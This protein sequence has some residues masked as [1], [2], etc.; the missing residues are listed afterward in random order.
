MAINWIEQIKNNY[1][2]YL[3]LHKR[4]VNISGI[5]IVKID[6]LSIKNIEK[7]IE[8]ISPDIIINCIGLTNIEECEK[9]PEIAKE[10]NAIIP[11]NV[12]KICKKFGIKFIQISTDHLFD[13]SQKLYKEEDIPNPQNQYAISK[14]QAEI[15]V[16]KILNNVSISKL[17]G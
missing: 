7:T 6:F 3:G 14:H 13:G 4:C 1:I 12:A 10:V 8:V 5:S 9:F 11:Y 2:V 17:I 16:S 15:N